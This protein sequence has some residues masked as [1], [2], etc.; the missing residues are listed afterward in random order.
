[1]TQR[2]AE[3]AG[4]PAPAAIAAAR[5]MAAAAMAQGRWATQQPV[6]VEVLGG[7]EVLRASPPEPP[8]ARVI[9]LWWWR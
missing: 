4:Y 7:C 6:L 5:A 9:H 2:L 3:R 1:M 8:R